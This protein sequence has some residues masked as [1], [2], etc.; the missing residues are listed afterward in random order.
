MLKIFSGNQRTDTISSGNSTYS[1]TD[2][3]VQRAVSS[4]PSVPGTRQLCKF[5]AKHDSHVYI[6]CPCL[7]R[8]E[9]R[10]LAEEGDWARAL[11]DYDA[12]NDEELSF[13]EGQL[14]R[15]LRRDENGVDDGW[16]EGE[17]DGQVGVFPS[18]V[19]EELTPVSP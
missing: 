17:V 1:A 8:S 13:S 10:F 18:L 3:E 11:Y 14:I 15:I 9:Y 12:T 6:I 19:V 16:W 4:Q 7:A 2:Y 5:S